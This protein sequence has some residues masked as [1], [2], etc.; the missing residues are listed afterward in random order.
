MSSKND[1]TRII[2][3]QKALKIAKQALEKADHN[4]RVD[5]IRDALDEIE[6]LDLN[7]KPSGLQG[8]CGHGR[9]VR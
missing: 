1:Q 6:M 3:L 9:N 2:A 5:H 4:G 8:L 7:S